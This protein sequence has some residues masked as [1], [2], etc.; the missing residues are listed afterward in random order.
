MLLGTR[1]WTNPT[2]AITGWS[3]SQDHSPVPS[4]GPS[5]GPRY[6]RPYRKDV[7]SSPDDPS[8][9]STPGSEPRVLSETV[10]PTGPSPAPKGRPSLRPGLRTT[11]PRPLPVDRR[12]PRPNHRPGPGARPRVPIRPRG[13]ETT[14]AEERHRGETRQDPEAE[15]ASVG[16]STPHPPR[17]VSSFL[18]HPWNSGLSCP[19]TRHFLVRPVI[20]P[21]VPLPDPGHLPRP[22]GSV[23]GGLGQSRRVARACDPSPDPASHRPQTPPRVNRP[24]RLPPQ[25]HLPTTRQWTTVRGPRLPRSTTE[26]A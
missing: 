11:S 7:D 4:Y 15:G 6:R 26:S 3:W 8:P 20:G 17:V 13:R 9:S 16:R 23:S 18:K 24:C 19:L 10:S 14:S 25:T 1:S 12:S 21:E 22:E 2:S 5:R